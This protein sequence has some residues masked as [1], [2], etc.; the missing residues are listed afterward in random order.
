MLLIKER[1][2]FLEK[3]IE[4]GFLHPSETPTPEAASAFPST[5]PLADVREK[6]V[7]LF[8]DESTFQANEDQ[9]TM[10]GR[11]GEHMLRPKS[12]GSGIMVSDFVDEKSG[13]LALT[14]DEFQKA[15]AENKA[16]WKEARCLLE[17]GES[18]EGYWYPD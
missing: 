11:K 2:I 4:I 3:M 17:Y 16:L 7:V 14:D 1:K 6:T 9:S 10:W 13:Y 5:V 12:K 8:H 18:R 15:S